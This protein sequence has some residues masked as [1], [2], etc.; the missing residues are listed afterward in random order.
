MTIQKVVWLRWRAA[1]ALAAS[2]LATGCG[3]TAPSFTYS[4]LRGAWVGDL[5]GVVIRVQLMTGPGF[6]SLAISG[7]GTL[8]IEATGESLPF[9]ASGLQ[10]TDQRSDDPVLINF[11]RDPLDGPSDQ[12]AQFTGRIIGSVIKGHLR[13]GSSLPAGPFTSLPLSSVDLRRP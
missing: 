1:V 6:G 3:P 10:F 5:N 7:T 9:N 8:T 12:Y 2:L 13:G 11:F 4:D